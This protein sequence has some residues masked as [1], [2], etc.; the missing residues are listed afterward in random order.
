M[1]TDGFFV[2]SEIQMNTNACDYSCR[3]EKLKESVE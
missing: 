2:I 3:A 1:R